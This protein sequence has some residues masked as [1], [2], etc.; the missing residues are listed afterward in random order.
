MTFSIT[1]SLCGPWAAPW[2]HLKP[3]DTIK[4]FRKYGSSCGFL[5][6][7]IDWKMIGTLGWGGV[8]RPFFQKRERPTTR[9]EY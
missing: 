7:L 2:N 5:S 6:M 3:E 9:Q 4:H 1:M 8:R